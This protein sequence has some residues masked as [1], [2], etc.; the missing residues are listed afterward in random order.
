MHVRLVSRPCIGCA[1]HGA[2]LRPHRPCGHLPLAADPAE[3]GRRGAGN[4]AAGVAHVE[5]GVAPQQGRVH[6]LQRGLGRWHPAKGRGAWPV[7]LGLH[8][9]AVPRG[10]LQHLAVVDVRARGGA[11]RARQRVLPLRL[12]RLLPAEPSRLPVQARRLQAFHWRDLHV[13]HAAGV[14]ERLRSDV[15]RHRLRPLGG[16][17]RAACGGGQGLLQ[18][19][20]VWP[21]D[22]GL[23]S[24]WR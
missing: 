19:S 11:G 14:A 20:R 3:D 2:A 12:L 24:A 4:A 21:S 9:R 10:R 16:R 5:G 6:V 18:G 23:P 1:G 7:Q 22:G 13:H 17:R 15:V 8:G